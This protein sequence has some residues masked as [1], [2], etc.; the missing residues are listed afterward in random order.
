MF[1]THLL[2][3]LLAMKTRTNNH[4]AITRT[5]R[6]QSSTDRPCRFRDQLERH[7]LDTLFNYDFA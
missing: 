4:W 7:T 6:N 3:K 5:Q 1:Q 2:Y